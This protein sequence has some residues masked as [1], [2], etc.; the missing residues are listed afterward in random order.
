VGGTGC[1]QG[2]AQAVLS[3][4]RVSIL[5][6][7][8]VAETD[9]GRSFDRKTCDFAVPVRVPAGITVGLIQVDYRGFANV[10]RGGFAEFSA[11]YF[12]AGHVGPRQ[13]RSFYENTS[14]DF[15]L[16]HRL[17]AVVWSQCGADVILRAN[18]SAMAR[19]SS[20]WAPNQTFL[21]VDS[22]DVAAGIEYQLVWGHC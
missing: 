19:K 22:A 12:F 3:G 21:Q 7:A 1:P 4:N 20:A 9:H 15:L 5:F 18:T 2:T 8:Y 6:D 14:R 16:R 13:R 17:G 11:E 10:P